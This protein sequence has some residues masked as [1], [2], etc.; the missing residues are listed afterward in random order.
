MFNK[1]YVGHVLNLYGAQ[2]LVVDREGQVYALRPE[3]QLLVPGFVFDTDTVDG[4]VAAAVLAKAG[5]P[6]LPK[7]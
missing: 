5:L 6:D 4:T 7:V 2:Q 1:E 3:G